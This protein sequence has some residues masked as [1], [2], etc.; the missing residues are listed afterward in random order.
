MTQG[1]GPFVLNI[2]LS[3]NGYPPEWNQEVFEKVLEEAENFK[4]YVR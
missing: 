3:Q 4:E 1:D 2:L